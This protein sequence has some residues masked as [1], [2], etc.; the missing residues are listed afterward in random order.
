MPGDIRTLNQGHTIIIII[1]NWQLKRPILRGQGQG[2][3]IPVQ[4]LKNLKFQAVI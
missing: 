1:S 2:I 4:E 3:T